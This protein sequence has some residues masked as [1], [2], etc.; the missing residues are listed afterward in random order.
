MLLR[1]LSDVYKGLVQNIPEDSRTDD[2][3]DLIAWLGAVVRQ[4]DSSL[5]DEWERLLDPPD[6]LG[7]LRRPA[8]PSGELT[9]VDDERAFR[10]MVRNQIFDWVQRLAA[11]RGYDAL[12]DVDEVAATMA[13]YWD[14]FDEILLDA[15]ARS[16]DRFVYDRAAQTVT[17]ILHDPAE[18]NEWRVVAR[19]DIDASREQGRAVLELLHIGS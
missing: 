15:G 8:L 6:D 12:G 13:P 2:I 7:E 19:V 14:E 11:R 17:Q 9:V 5:I 16:P 18:G 3:D 4:V 1:Y 10:V